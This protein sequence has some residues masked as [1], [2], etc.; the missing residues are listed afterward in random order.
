MESILRGD[1]LVFICTPNN[2]TGILVDAEHLREIATRNPSTLFVVDEAFGD[3]VEGMDSLT[4][5]RPPN[6]IVLLSLTKIYTIPGLRLGLAICEPKIVESIK[7]IQPTWSV[8]SIAQAVGSAALR[9]SHYVE[10]SRSFV[11]QQREI[12]ETS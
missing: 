4:R 7:R 9:D 8:N 5:N 11:R 1:E 10:Q 6:V 3:F 2:P 12:L